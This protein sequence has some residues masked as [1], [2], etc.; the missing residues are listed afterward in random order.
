METGKWK[1]R[2]QAAWRAFLRWV[3]RAA[4]RASARPVRD[5]Q[6]VRVHPMRN[7]SNVLEVSRETVL[8]KH[9]ESSNGHLPNRRISRE[10]VSSG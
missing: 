3:E 8:K 9:E 1:G 7:T 4:C 10:S 5:T 2:C 6:L